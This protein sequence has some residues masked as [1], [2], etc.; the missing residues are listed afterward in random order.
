MRL[1]LIRE[2]RAGDANE[3]NDPRVPILKSAR[4]ADE[5]FHMGMRHMNAGRDGEAFE[6]FKSL[7]EFKDWPPELLSAIET[8]YRT[9]LGR[10]VDPYQLSELPHIAP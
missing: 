3:G 9:L 4:E 1:R 10:T 7:A 5:L 8:L 2:H 6:I